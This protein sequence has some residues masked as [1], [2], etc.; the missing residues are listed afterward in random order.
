MEIKLVLNIEKV[1]VILQALAERP[2]KDIAPLIMEIEAQ[3]NMQINQ[4]EAAVEQPAETETKKDEDDEI[5]D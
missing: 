4:V 2:Y 1:N 5:Q 3:G